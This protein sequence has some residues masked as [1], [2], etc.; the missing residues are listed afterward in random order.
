MGESDCV[1]CPFGFITPLGSISKEECVEEVSASSR[2]EGA[3]L[4]Q[5]F[6]VEAVV[7][8]SMAKADFDDEKRAS[9]VS[10]VAATAMVPEQDVAIVLVV[11]RTSRRATSLLVT[12]Q[13]RVNDSQQASDVAMSMNDLDK[14]NDNF[15]KE[16]MPKALVVSATVVSTDKTADGQTAIPAGMASSSI[17]GIAVTVCVVLLCAGSLSVYLFK[18]R[19]PMLAIDASITAGDSRLW[20]E[21]PPSIAGV[22]HELEMGRKISARTVKPAAGALENDADM[23]SSHRLRIPPAEANKFSTTQ[24]QET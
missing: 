17:I 12:S 3:E 16:G 4:N 10:A 22:Q 11:E 13:V 21:P 19:G 2:E 5:S 6:Q 15:R 24:N 20:Q 9:F 7:S 1:L 18:G 8:L 14:L 23:Y